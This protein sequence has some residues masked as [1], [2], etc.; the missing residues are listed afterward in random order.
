MGIPQVD[1]TTDHRDPVRSD[2]RRR[3]MRRIPSIED[4]V[5]AAGGPLD[6]LDLQRRIQCAH[7]DIEARV[8]CIARLE[9]LRA[10]PA[11][12]GE[13]DAKITLM[14]FSHE[15]RSLRD[16]WYWMFPEDAHVRPSVSDVLERVGRFVDPQAATGR[17]KVPGSVEKLRR[18]CLTEARRC[19][20]PLQLAQAESR[21][22]AKL[23]DL[24]LSSG[25]REIQPHP[26]R[27]TET[28][29]T[30][31]Q[32][33]EL[34]RLYAVCAD[35]D[36]ELGWLD[37][38]RSLVTI[39]VAHGTPREVRLLDPGVRRETTGNSTRFDAVLGFYE[40]LVCRDDLMRLEGEGVSWA[41]T[42]PWIRGAAGHVPKSAAV[43]LWKRAVQE[44][45]TRAR[46]DILRGE[47]FALNSDRRDLQEI[48]RRARVLVNESVSRERRKDRQSREQ[49]EGRRKRLSSAVIQVKEPSLRPA[50]LEAAYAHS[51]LL[52]HGLAELRKRGNLTGAEFLEA[53]DFLEWIDDRRSAG[54]DL[55]AEAGEKPWALLHLYVHD[56]T[57]SEGKKKLS[58]SAEPGIVRRADTGFGAGQN[59][60]SDGVPSPQ[61]IS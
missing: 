39:S 6:V 14:W 46:E 3:L 41:G 10:D 13:L 36:A 19:C 27:C 24:V 32:R 52:R 51:N 55:P 22:E 35:Q 7:D 38:T 59:D 53:R 5:I 20:W 21:R 4:Q 12:V 29:M 43:A 61:A 34:R 48:N 56:L 33:E 45:R 25:M 49:G 26:M 57:T 42:P 44:A 15:C 58:Q 47:Q 50:I 54:L 11:F 16:R 30:L 8:V 2:I 9:A 17:R 18:L 31:C 23:F 60:Q 40:G 1:S 28:D 37:L